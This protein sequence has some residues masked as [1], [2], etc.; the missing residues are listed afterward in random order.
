MKIKQAT[1]QAWRSAAGRTKNE[2][3]NIGEGKN[4]NRNYNE[5]NNESGLK[6][7]HKDDN[8]KTWAQIVRELPRQYIQQSI[9]TSNKTNKG[10]WWGHQMPSKK[11]G[12]LRLGLRNINSLPINSSHS[13][14]SIFTAEI[15]D[16]NFDIFCATEVNVAWSNLSEKDKC[17]ERFRGHFEFAKIIT[18]NNKDNT[19]SDKFQRGGTLMVCQGHTCGRVIS[20][21]TDD[22]IL[23][24]WT[25]M[26][27]R[28][29]RGLSVVIAT[30]YRPVFNKGALSTYQQHKNVLRDK[31]IDTCPR[32]QL[33]DDL[34]EEIKKG[35]NDGNQVIITGDFNEDVGGANITKYFSDLQMNEIILTQH[36]GPAPNTYLDGSVPIDGIFVSH[37][38]EGVFSGYGSFSEGMYS[39]TQDVMGRF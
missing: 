4:T 38:I 19:Y 21:G 11:E 7:V 14:N 18:S 33:L 9:R 28:G 39:E 16:G 15:M 29:C 37:G 17:S 26:K 6:N 22:N 5:K 32:K 2:S 8:E 27:L 13:K 34:A 30:V 31:D 1:L 24:R 23:G 3:Q 12:H 36:D 10:T 35:K 25:W 20:S